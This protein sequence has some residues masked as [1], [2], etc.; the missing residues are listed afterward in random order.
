MK[1]KCRSTYRASQLQIGTVH[2]YQQ[3]LMG[4]GGGEGRALGEKKSHR[5]GTHIHR[6]HQPI[7][8]SRLE[9]FKKAIFL[10]TNYRNP[11]NYEVELY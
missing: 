10:L 9:T 2:C 7:I 5:M 11:S 3:K 6:I 8:N 4:G 1:S